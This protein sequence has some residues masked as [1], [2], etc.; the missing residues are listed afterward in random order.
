MKKL[1]ILFAIPLAFACRK[2]NMENYCMDC[3]ERTSTEFIDTLHFL[4][5]V[6]SDWFVYCKDSLYVQ[7]SDDTVDVVVNG[8]TYKALQ[9]TYL[10]CK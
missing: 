5:P 7:S 3:T 1:L 2:G 6:D 10:F 9:N 8:K 4:E